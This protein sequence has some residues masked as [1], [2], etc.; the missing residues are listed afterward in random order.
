MAIMADEIAIN[1]SRRFGA[2]RAMISEVSTLSGTIQAKT[3]AVEMEIMMVQMRSFPE[4][5]N[6]LGLPLVRLKATP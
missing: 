4:Q 2:V 1:R 5:K 6:F 3:A